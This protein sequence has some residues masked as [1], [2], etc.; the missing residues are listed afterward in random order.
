[1]AKKNFRSTAEKAKA[2]TDNV[3]KNLMQGRYGFD[4]YSMFLLVTG[5]ILMIIGIIT[6]NVPGT[7]LMMFATWEMIYAYIRSMSKKF[8]LR[9]AQNQKYL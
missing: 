2:K 1:M 4:N 8:D 9:R 5:I 3:L 6:N 7:I